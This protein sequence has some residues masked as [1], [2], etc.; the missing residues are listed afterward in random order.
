[1]DR[2]HAVCHGDDRRVHLEAHDGRRAGLRAARNPPR[3]PEVVRVPAADPCNLVGVTSAGPKV[4]AV[5]GNAVLYRDGVAIASLEAGQLV[6]RHPLDDG[7]TV[8]G[9]LAYH[10]PPRTD[11]PQQVRLPL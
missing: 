1:M 8:D 7:A 11:E 6:L 3:F 5:V 4:P 9:D 10:P 2:G